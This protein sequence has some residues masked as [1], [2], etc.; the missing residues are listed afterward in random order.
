MVDVETIVKA[1]HK[2]GE[3]MLW[4]EGRQCLFWIDLSDPMLCSYDPASGI[5]TRHALALPPPIGA[6]AATT[7]TN[8]LMLAHRGGLSLLHIDS[9][10]LTPYGDPEQGRDGVIYN[11]MKVDRWGRLWVGTSHEKEILPRGALWCVENAKKF[12]LGDVGFAVSNGPAFS[13]DGRVMYFSDSANRQILTYDV[14]PDHLHSKGRRVFSTF[15]TEEGVPDGL[16]VDAEGC[17]W[18]AQWGGACVFRLSPKGEKLKRIA[19]PAYQVTSVVL[20]GKTLFITSA[21]EGL[22][23]DILKEYPLTGSVFSLE[24]DVAGLPEKLF[25]L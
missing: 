15:T 9:L 6:I 2:L 8:V 19:V 7:D 16:T 3:S 13:P 25:P 14:S 20:L 11:D 5:S 22:S 12:A 23:A 21:R 18:S 24:T 10:Q 1:E 4:H 17:V